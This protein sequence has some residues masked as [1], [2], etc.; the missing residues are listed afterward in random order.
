MAV[1]GVYS[2]LSRREGH[3]GNTAEE[4]ARRPNLYSNPFQNLFGA[5]LRQQHD[6]IRMLGQCS[7]V[8]VGL[9]L[10]TRWGK[11][12]KLLQSEAPAGL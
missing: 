11:V 3:R 2:F 5:L 7:P 9:L 12:D 6:G 4:I 8:T 1:K 10:D